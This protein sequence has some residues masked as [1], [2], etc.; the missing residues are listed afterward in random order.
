MVNTPEQST[1]YA[2]CLSQTGKSAHTPAVSN[3][4][5]IPQ[6]IRKLSPSPPLDEDVL[7][8]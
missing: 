3:Y 6:L 7:A 4:S 1:P 8:G 5:S 2:L